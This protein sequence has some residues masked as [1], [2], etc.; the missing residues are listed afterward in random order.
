MSP[1]LLPIAR[2]EITPLG[3]PMNNRSRKAHVRLRC[4]GVEQQRPTQW[5]DELTG[6]PD[7]R[8]PSWSATDGA[9]AGTQA[10]LRFG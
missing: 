5:R 8:L 6:I 4:S 3:E 10:S 1:P 2:E 9:I 7:V